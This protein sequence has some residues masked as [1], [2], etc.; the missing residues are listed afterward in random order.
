MIQRLDFS[1]HGLGQVI[2]LKLKSDMDT[3]ESENL[4]N[5]TEQMSNTLVYR[6]QN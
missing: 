6:F 1:D 5:D 2:F 4:D 3:D